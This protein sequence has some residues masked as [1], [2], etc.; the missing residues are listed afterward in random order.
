MKRELLEVLRRTNAFA[1]FRLAN[2]RKALILVYHRFGDAPGATSARVLAEQLDYLRRRYAFVALSAFE[3]AQF[4]GVPLPS[5]AVAITIDDGYRDVFET[6]WPVFRR[7]G[8]PATLFAVTNFIDGLGWVWTDKLRY[9]LL[10]TTESTLSVSLGG[11]THDVRLDSGSSRLAAA[12]RLNEAL[13]QQDEDT[14][15]AFITSVSRLA[16]VAI[17]ASPP[18]EYAA[19][20]WDELRAMNTEGIEI[21]SH[22]VSHPILTNVDGDRL[23]RELTASRARLESML[24]RQITSFCY[25]NG[26]CNRQVRDEAARAG[27]RIAVTMQPGLNDA[28]TDP[29]LLK[30]I[31]TEADLT[32]FIQSTSGFEEVKN[33]VRLAYES[34]RRDRKEA[35]DFLY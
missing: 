2:R 3:R 28:S 34:N 22:T 1:P 17:P 5:R 32:H 14:K 20:S 30:R 7:Y 6:A 9:V 4:D 12:H 27:Y 29:L 11:A 35:R 19:A 21:G 24:G 31:H 33:R 26:A 10:R 18:P 13:K 15:D 16:R 8:V 25:P 23:V